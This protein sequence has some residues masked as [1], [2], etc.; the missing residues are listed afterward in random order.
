MDPR[1]KR[2]LANEKRRSR[3]KK[4]GIWLDNR[5]KVNIHGKKFIK[6]VSKVCAQCKIRR[7]FHHH[8]LCQSC[9]NARESQYKTTT[10]FINPD[11]VKDSETNEHGKTEEIYQR[12][13]DTAL[14]ECREEGK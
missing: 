5:F 2:R 13:A 12:T 14:S 1:E 6:P 8:K 9:W 10:I 4:W 3:R 7:V 11:T